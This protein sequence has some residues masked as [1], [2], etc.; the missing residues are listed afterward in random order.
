[1][2]VIDDHDRTV[3]GRT[4]PKLQGGFGLSGQ[5]KN[6]DFNANF[7]Y[8]LDFDVYNAT[9]YY[10][11]SSID[12]KNNFKNVL[13]SFTNRWRYA[14]GSECLY[15]NTWMQGAY[16]RYVEMNEGQTRWN[17]MDLNKDV[18]MSYFVEDGS[19]LRCTDI[20]LGYNLPQ[21]LI[22]KAGMSKLRFYA[23]VTNPF[24]LTG[25]TGYDPEVDVQ[26]GL[27]PSFDFNRYPRS[28]SY[29]FGLN[30]TF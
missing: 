25:Y 18:T 4:T 10:L 27:T 26:S 15:G 5:W 17:P 19:F 30:V 24:I 12:N 11:S 7:T 9:A 13:S 8:F 28:R 14:E 16:D 6:F 23:S 21:N 22:T 3:I 29:V 1:D 2:G 20:T